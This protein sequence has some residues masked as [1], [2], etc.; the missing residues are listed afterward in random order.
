[1]INADIKLTVCDLQEFKMA[2]AAEWKWML[3][4]VR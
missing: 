2:D 1:M 4:E 3:K